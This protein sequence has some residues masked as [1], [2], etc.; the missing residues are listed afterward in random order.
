[1]KNSMIALFV[2]LVLS[3]CEMTGKDWAR[4]TDSMSSSEFG[5]G[6]CQFENSYVS[7]GHSA[8]VYADVETVCNSTFFTFKSV[9]HNTDYKC[10]YTIGYTR[11]YTI[12]YAGKQRELSFAAREGSRE[13]SFQCNVY[14]RAAELHPDNS[15]FKV[16]Y[17][18]GITYA[19]LRNDESYHIKCKFTDGYGDV[20]KSDVIISPN[21]W[22]EFVEYDED[23]NTSCQRR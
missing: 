19:S 7:L 9:S 12:V 20:L 2:V 18:N 15:D 22:S 8:D 4:V 11:D 23:L 1:M 13:V 21:G 10:Y 16:K 17:V 14:N 5:D 3:G 6:S